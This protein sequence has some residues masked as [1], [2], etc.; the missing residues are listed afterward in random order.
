MNRTVR[1]L[2]TCWIALAAAR[3]G[4][5]FNQQRHETAQSAQKGFTETKLAEAL[6]AERTHNGEILA[7][8]IAIATRQL[9]AAR[10]A[11]LINIVNQE[12]RDKSLE[13]LTGQVT[14]RL[15]ELDDN[16]RE[17]SRLLTSIESREESLL[18]AKD[19]YLIRRKSTDPK[20][21]CTSEA[22]DF[23]S[24]NAKSGWEFIQTRCRELEDDRR[25]LAELAEAGLIGRLSAKIATTE[26]ARAQLEAELAI[27]EKKAKA[28]AKEL[29]TE[30]K[31]ANRF[32]ADR[33]AALRK[34]VEDVEFPTAAQLGKFGID[35][36]RAAA[37]LKFA[38]MQRDAIDEVLG[39]ATAGKTD[40]AKDVDAHLQI[41]AVLPTIAQQ[42]RE[43]KAAPRILTLVIESE[44]LRVE[45]NRHRQ[46]LARVAEELD[47]SRLKLKRLR[48]ERKILLEA[49]A[50]LGD[51]GRCTGTQEACKRHFEK[52]LQDYT[53]SWT[54]A[55]IPATEIDWR[56]IDLAHVRTLDDS[57]AALAQWE[58]LVRAPLE[59]IVTSTARGLHPDDVARLVDAIQFG[60]LAAGVY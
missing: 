21:A 57:Q 49:Q 47:L 14:K 38:E 55:R 13:L 40:L 1:M 8:E 2:L 54:L 37:A 18:A 30:R 27:A 36:A 53:D 7:R 41:A 56:L 51:L 58:G 19:R 60:A 34:T 39:A 33:L 46:R 17:L 43:G 28:A 26:A 42:L 5:L 48:D 20:I 31:R 32:N 22:F 3:C 52:A 11:N 29:A 25:K 35:D 44:R 6:D 50:A 12:S 4:T 9:S 15:T 10:D 16:K 23:S 59:A 45:A 24:E